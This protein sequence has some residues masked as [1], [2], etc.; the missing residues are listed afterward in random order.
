MPNQGM[1]SNKTR[2]EKLE[3][4]ITKK[5]DG[6]D[7]TALLARFNDIEQKYENANA[8][9]QLMSET[10]NLKQNTIDLLQTQIGSLRDT[11]E[12][13]QGQTDRVDQ[14]SMRSNL[15]IH[16]VSAPAG[17]ETNDVV[18]QTVKDVASDLGVDINDDDLFRAHRVGKVV[19]EINKEG[20][21][22]GRKIQPIIVRFRSWNKRCELYK[23]RPKR[24]ANTPQAERTIKFHSIG[25]DLA[26]GTRELLKK[27]QDLIKVKFQNSNDVFAFADINCNISVKLANNKFVICNDE[28]KLMKTINSL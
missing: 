20:R 5:V 13:L 26:R 23:A 19:D 7:F 4:E 9:M 17:V 28:A 11:V 1:E 6:S 22:T 3:D 21:K 14:Y 12:T 25:L 27:G 2:L 18:V 10:I 16:G 15:R 8:K 24:R